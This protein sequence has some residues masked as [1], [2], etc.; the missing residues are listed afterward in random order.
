MKVKTVRLREDR[1]KEIDKIAKEEGKQSAEVL[2]EIIEKGLREYKI[3]RAIE[4]YQRGLHSQGAA[5]EKAG[6]SVQEFH[7]ELKRRGFTLRMDAKLIE[8]ELKDL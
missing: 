8:A 1:I 6:L 5:A 7:Q 3:E 2:R 4:E